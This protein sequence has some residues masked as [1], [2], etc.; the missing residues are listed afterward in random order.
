MWS[1]KLKGLNVNLSKTIGS[2]I[3]CYDHKLICK[4]QLRNNKETIVDKQQRHEDL[5]RW[6]MNASCLCAILVWYKTS[7]LWIHW[8]TRTWSGCGWCGVYVINLAT[9]SLFHTYGNLS[10]NIQFQISHDFYTE[11][12]R[13]PMVGNRVEHETSTSYFHVWHLL[14]EKLHNVSGHMLFELVNLQF[15]KW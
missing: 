7:G 11:I 4:I 6:R 10:N 15:R 5:T 9:Y 2:L 1:S 14:E 8:I 12:C 13:T 3:E